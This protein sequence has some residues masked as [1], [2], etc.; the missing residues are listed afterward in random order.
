MRTAAIGAHAPRARALGVQQIGDPLEDRGDV[1]VGGR[2]NRAGRGL[3][4]ALACADGV[5]FAGLIASPARAL[6]LV[7]PTCRAQSEGVLHHVSGLRQTDLHEL[8]S[9]AALVQPACR[10]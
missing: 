3:G 6:T 5:G 4:L 10:C 2:A 8:P 1:G 7:T 9:A